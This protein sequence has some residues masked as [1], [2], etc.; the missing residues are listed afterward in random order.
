MAGVIYCVSILESCAGGMLILFGGAA[1]PFCISFVPSNEAGC[2]FMTDPFG[3]VDS[4][5]GATVG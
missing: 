4:L 3:R 5:S 1:P 2:L